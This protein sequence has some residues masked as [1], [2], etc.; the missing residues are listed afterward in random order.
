MPAPPLFA[1]NV[2]TGSVSV[3]DLEL[4]EPVTPVGLRIYVTFVEVALSTVTVQVAL[5]ARYLPVAATDAVIVVVPTESGVTF[6]AASTV[7][8]AVLLDS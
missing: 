4:P 8:T 3:T 6:P 1:V 5:P 7:A 2:S